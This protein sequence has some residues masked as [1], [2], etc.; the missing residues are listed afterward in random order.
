MNGSHMKAASTTFDSR[1]G[2]M[3]PEG[4]EM[5]CASSSGTSP[6]AS[7]NTKPRSSTSMPDPLRTPAILRPSRSASAATPESLRLTTAAWP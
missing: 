7:P 6:A 1:D 2:P 4:M 3:L 5:I